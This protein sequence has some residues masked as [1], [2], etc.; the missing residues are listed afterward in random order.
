MKRTVLGAFICAGTV[1][2]LNATRTNANATVVAAR[3]PDGCV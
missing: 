1:V 2:A 3:L